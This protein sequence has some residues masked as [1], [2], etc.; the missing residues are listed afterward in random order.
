MSP[1]FTI[2]PTDFSTP[3]TRDL[4]SLHLA[5]MHDNTPA[6]HVFALDLSGLMAPEIEV[7]TVHHLDH[8]AGIGALK[9]LN[10]QTGELKS[11]RTHPDFLRQGVA[12]TLL[13]HLIHRA[14]SEGMKTL[15]LETGRGSSF[16][17]ALA[18]YQSRGFQPG[19][20]FGDY[21]A[22]EFNQFFHLTL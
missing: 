3:Q 20:A 4:L 12:R 6:G 16:K 5:G 21:Q 10:D 2:H 14:R 9:R 17:P 18:F 19:E 1:T 22:S 13:D 8:V 7:W 11:M 15:S